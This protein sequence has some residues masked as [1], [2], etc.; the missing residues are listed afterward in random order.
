MVR[1]SP[2]S[3]ARCALL[4]VI[5]IV[6]ISSTD[7]ARLLN[8]TYEVARA[9]VP[10]LPFY[11][12]MQLD[13]AVVTLTADEPIYALAG[14]CA[15]GSA[16]CSESNFMPCCDP[17]D[18]DPVLL[19][20]RPGVPSSC[21]C[22]T[23]PGSICLDPSHP[24][25]RTGDEY[26]AMPP[27]SNI[28]FEIPLARACHTTL[29]NLNVLR[30]NSNLYLGASSQ[31]AEGVKAG[32]YYSSTQYTNNVIALC[33]ADDDG[34][35]P[36]YSGFQIPNSHI[37]FL[38]DVAPD[39]VARIRGVFE[40][41]AQVN[42]TVAEVLHPLGL[43]RLHDPG[44]RQ[45]SYPLGFMGVY[46]NESDYTVSASAN[47][48][49]YFPVSLAATP[50]PLYDFS[51]S[52]GYMKPF[53]FADVNPNQAVFVLPV[54]S[55]VQF[56][57]VPIAP[58]LQRCVIDVGALYY[59]DGT[60]LVPAQDPVTP[61]YYATAVNITNYV[62]P[63]LSAN[64]PCS[65]ANLEAKQAEVAALAAAFPTNV[66]PVTLGFVNIWA[67]GGAG[68]SLEASACSRD[69][70]DYLIPNTY[71][72]NTTSCTSAPGSSE[73]FLDPC[74]NVDLRRTSCCLA[75]PKR[76]VTR[77]TDELLTSS[78]AQPEC[79]TLTA[80]TL[81][82]L[83]SRQAQ[84]TAESVEYQ[85]RTFDL[86]SRDLRVVLSTNSTPCTDELNTGTDEEFI[87]CVVAN[88]D[89]NYKAEFF[90][91]WGVDPTSTSFEAALRQRYTLTA[92]CLQPGVPPYNTSLLVPIRN[93][94]L[95]LDRAACESAPSCNWG[96]ELTSD[97]CLNSYR[98][99]NMCASCTDGYCEEYSI[100]GVCFTPRF[101]VARNESWQTTCL[102]NSGII[103][104]EMGCIFPNKS[105]SKAAC[106]NTPVCDSGP[107][108]PDYC[109]NN[110]YF[111]QLDEA[112]CQCPSV[113]DVWC[114]SLYFDPTVNLCTIPLFYQNFDQYDCLALGGEYWIGALWQEGRLADNA[115]CTSAGVFCPVQPGLNQTECDAIA[116]VQLG[117]CD[118]YCPGC[119][120]TQCEAAV[121]CRDRGLFDTPYGDSTC[122]TDFFLYGS[123]IYACSFG[124]LADSSLG[125]VFNDIYTFATGDV[126][127]G[128]YSCNMIAAPTI[129]DQ[130]VCESLGRCQETGFSN[131][132]TTPKSKEDCLRCG[133]TWVQA[134]TWG[135]GVYTPPPAA[136]TT[137]PVAWVP[138]QYAPRFTWGPM[139]NRSGFVAD[140]YAV[141]GQQQA[142][143]ARQTSLCRSG[144]TLD[145]V[146]SLE[147][148]C[149]GG[150]STQCFTAAQLSAASL[151]AIQR[152]CKNVTQTV[153]VLPALSVSLTGT[154][155][156]AA[157]CVDMRVSTVPR[158]SYK[159]GNRLASS[160]LFLA[161]LARDPYAVIQN[162]RHVVIGA[163]AGDGIR[164][165]FSQNGTAALSE[166]CVNIDTAH[167][168]Q[169]TVADF[170]SVSS[171]Y[172]CVWLLCICVE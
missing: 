36:L 45:I 91:R 139:F 2:A 101:A 146:T 49:P 93:E 9:S 46:C 135:N 141:R 54:G 82:Q 34:S 92:G 157:A 51:L 38:T 55:D 159:S 89:Q 171:G 67:A 5:C 106:F 149:N 164:L 126:W 161:S 103:D 8:A 160:T 158:N 39:G 22:P 11:P 138:R 75:T 88:L 152:A 136:V 167:S 119:N 4:A 70:T 59:A 63:T 107:N 154:Q 65:V 150:G 144:S 1:S 155:T 52:A 24:I 13:L 102:A 64:R 108:S 37:L 17:S 66:N 47:P 127:S 97:E 90:T 156:F 23:L 43:V 21:A 18:C 77:A 96:A 134:F 172:A 15:Q 48:P 12:T 32:Y 58:L 143:A 128:V 168:S 35:I 112:A 30:G 123:T 140:F 7:G 53:S 62:T 28:V 85:S 27:F 148:D 105:S 33:A 95:D 122:L 73:F 86:F 120:Q 151:Q 69:A 6:A 25:D 129:T 110:C 81:A 104:P 42:I 124:A 50:D 60:P 80:D 114:G 98:G 116:P 132:T 169:Y 56:S 118:V 153:A 115:S 10:L 16:L 78:C 83:L 163:I 72:E 29:I 26:L 130:T 31:T 125:C 19:T 40:G 142:N 76:V 133:G 113:S 170:A 162:D 131:T 68:S 111:P 166:L 165:E 87:A 44:S 137:V 109:Y 71:V 3:G 84:C 117:S 79:A 147:C 121:G 99:P 94:S 61:P 20:R 14:A 74:C 100:T 41:A 145:L 57:G